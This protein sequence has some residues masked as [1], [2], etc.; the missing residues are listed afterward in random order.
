M[1][2]IL[3][4]LHLLESRPFAETLNT[5]LAQR[6]RCL[7]TALAR[8][9]DRLPNG[10]GSAAELS[11]AHTVASDGRSRK[12][13]IRDMRHRLKTVLEIVCKTL[14]SSRDVFLGG[15]E[16]PPL[17]RQ[18]LAHI[19]APVPSSS[20]DL[21]SEVRLT[22][23]ALLSSL[24]SSN[25]FLLLPSTVKSYKP[26]VDVDSLSSQKEARFA[27]SLEGWFATSMETVR[28][29]MT[30]WFAELNTIRELWEM[31]AW[32]RQWLQTTQG[33][34]REEKAALHACIDEIC[35]LRAVEIWKSVL[36]SIDAAFREHLDSALSELKQTSRQHSLGKYHH[37]LFCFTSSRF[38][39]T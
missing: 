31:R 25:H 30:S 26:Y 4:A 10:N 17:M 38:K 11:L 20:D 1:C 36:S 23:Q 28:S 12:I 34:Q 5:F 37:A 16:K 9:K 29:A 7:T 3:L 18:V 24:P 2:A 21:P 8:S 32:C 13:V 15:S 14:G 33:A 6:T 39:L 22:S 35:R 27:K 19:Q